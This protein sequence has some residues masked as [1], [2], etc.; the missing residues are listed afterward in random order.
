MLRSSRA[1][2]VKVVSPSE[3]GRSEVENLDGGEHEPP[4]VR[5]ATALPPQHVALDQSRFAR[6][7]EG[8]DI[9]QER[10]R[11][12]LARA[13]RRGLGWA[14]R[15]AGLIQNGSPRSLTCRSAKLR[16]GW[17]SHGLPCN[18][19]W[20]KNP[21]D[22]S[23]EIRPKLGDPTPRSGRPVI[24]CIYRAQPVGSSSDGRTS[25]DHDAVLYPR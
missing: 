6:F 5:L 18:G 9:V 22:R 20:P 19:S 3:R 11:A 14:D 1:A 21:Q 12:G 13:K 25:A 16:G 7:S 4:W 15:G 8:G 10:V 2:A 17:V 23:S 24:T